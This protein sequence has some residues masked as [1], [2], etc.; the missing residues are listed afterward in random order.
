ITVTDEASRLRFRAA[1]VPAEVG[2]VPD[3]ALLAARLHPPE[4]LAKR[5]DYLQLMGWYPLHGAPL[6]IEA[7]GRLLGEAAA[8]AQALAACRQERPGLDIVVAETGCPGDAACADALIAAM[9]AAGL[10]GA[11]F[12]LPSTAGLEDLAAGVASCAAFCA[13]TVRGAL[14]AAAHGRPAVLLGAFPDGTR[15]AGEP[16]ALASSAADLPGAL[17]LAL[18]TPVA[19]ASL[20]MLHK[21]LDATLDDVAGAVT[22]A[23]R[24]RREPPPLPD[25][26]RIASLEERLG[27]LATAHDARSRRLAT[28][29]M[30]FANHLRKAEEE[31]AALKVEAQ[32]LREE[33]S[34]AQNRVAHAQAEL[35][36]EAAA[37]AAIEAELI[38]LRATRTFR[39]TAELRSAYGRLRRIAAPPEPP[40][41]PTREP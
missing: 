15:I 26:A 5:L 16:A 12:R 11:T 28:E 9:A 19:P 34:R 13:T 18:A 35:S 4:L 32:R 40:P 31:I 22:A 2:I 7:H 20:G 39:Y 1:N 25:A 17:A 30:V 23:A 6:V 37:R 27:H 38:G 21:E 3:L 24:R 29:R 8:L 41:E 33:A 36:A 10:G 14:I